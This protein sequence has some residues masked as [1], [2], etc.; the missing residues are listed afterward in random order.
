[1]EPTNGAGNVQ[2][3]KEQESDEPDESGA[4]VSFDD[5]EEAYS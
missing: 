5:D 2:E 3:D 4:S 1:M